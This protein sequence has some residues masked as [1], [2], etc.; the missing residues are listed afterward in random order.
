MDSSQQHLAQISIETENNFSSSSH[1]IDTIAYEG[2]KVQPI[3]KY[4]IP[5][6]YNK[7]YLRILPVN[8]STYY[9]YWEASDQMLLGNNIDLNKKELRLRLLDSNGNLLHEFSSKFALGEYFV[10]EIIED[11]DIYVKMG[12]MNGNDFI[13]L[14]SSNTIH[15]FSTQLKWPSPQSEV[16]IKKEKGWTEIIRSTMQHFAL[17]MSSDQYLEEIERLKSLSSVSQERLSSTSHIKGKNN[18]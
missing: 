1:A 2:R 6:R 13:E 3:S 7:D 11:M 10:N 17:G 16:W 14:L 15:T 9:V 8:T 4:E 12:I 18:G 5:H